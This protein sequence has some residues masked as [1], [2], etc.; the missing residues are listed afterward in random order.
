[1]FEILSKNSTMDETAYKKASSAM[2]TSKKTTLHAQILVGNKS[3]QR[4][5]R[6][7]FTVG[8]WTLFLTPIV[9]S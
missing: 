4:E 1:M 7:D 8:K 6:F 3:G 2:S 5:Y 9:K